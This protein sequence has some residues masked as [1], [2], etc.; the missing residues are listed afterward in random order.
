MTLLGDVQTKLTVG[1]QNGADGALVNVRG[2]KDGS[3]V[4][5]SH[6]G[7]YN[8]LARR[9]GLF[10]GS[11]AAA[12]V[13]LPI[14]SSTTQ[15]F[16]LNNP[17]GSGKIAVLQK[18]WVGYVSGT[19]VAGHLCYANQTVLDKAVAGTDGLIQNARLGNAAA[20][21]GSLME[22]LVAVTVTALTYL[23]AFGLNTA[24]GAAATAMT[25]W[26][27]TDDLD[28]SIVVP[29]GSCIAIAANKAAAQTAAVSL[30]WNEE[31][32]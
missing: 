16:V 22:I 19:H 14:F 25:P 20:P 2:S 23:R 18:A 27:A 7:K 28:G 1:P 31:D 4:L 10:I 9:G 8:E 13:Q 15:Q 29:P 11:T 26:Q 3:T 32:V 12:G 21:S 24:V 17:A 30:M 6:K 5:S